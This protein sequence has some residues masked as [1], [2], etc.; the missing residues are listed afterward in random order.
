MKREKSSQRRELTPE[1]IA[2]FAERAI[3]PSAKLEGRVVPAG[4]E[5]SAQVA[6][7]IAK[8]HSRG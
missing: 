6:A 7:I 2:R 3:K 1:V 5:P 4:Y 8:R